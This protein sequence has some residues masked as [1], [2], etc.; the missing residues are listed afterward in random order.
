MNGDNE[1]LKIVNN[2][3]SSNSNIMWY[4]ES[5]APQ[6]RMWTDAQLIPY[7][8]PVLEDGQSYQVQIGYEL[9]NIVTYHKNVELTPDASWRVFSSPALLNVI[10]TGNYYVDLHDAM[11]R[12]IPFGLNKMSVQD[13]HIIFQDRFPA[14]FALPLYAD[15][16][17]YDGHTED[18][19]LR[20]DGSTPMIDGYVPTNDYDVVTKKYLLEKYGPAQ[21]LE[22][23][24]PDFIDKAT[25]W[26][27]DLKK[28][29]TSV[30][31]NEEFNFL[32]E[33]ETL[34]IQCSPIYNV[35]KGVIYLCINDY[36]VASIPLKEA[37]DGLY[38]GLLNVKVIDPYEKTLL[39][40]GHYQSLVI[41][42]AINVKDFL[43]YVGNVSS[44]MR[45]RLEWRYNAERKFTNE[46]IYGIA[47]VQRPFKIENLKISNVNEVVQ[48]YI[49][50]IPTLKEGTSF[51][52]SGDIQGIRKFKNP[53]LAKYDCSFH[54]EKLIN[55]DLTYTTNFPKYHFNLECKVPENF[56]CD[57]FHFMIR[58]F[59]ILREQQAVKAFWHK[60]YIDTVSVE[61]RVTSGE[62]LFPLNFGKEYD[63]EQSLVDNHELMLKNGIYQFPEGNYS[64]YNPELGLESE[65][66]KG[67]NYD[68]IPHETRWATFRYDLDYCSGL[69]IN[70]EDFECIYDKET[71][72]LNEVY[73]FVKTPT[74]GWLNANK[75]YN[76]ISTPK[77][78]DDAA[79]VIP[80][81]TYDK[82]YVTFGTEMIKGPFFVRIGFANNTKFKRIDCIAN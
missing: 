3:I 29:A 78:D 33:N 72:I 13:G 60:F 15:F 2:K 36:D 81:S 68:K 40:H 35:G 66:L 65:L 53:L 20:N 48:K 47:P 73:L 74:T 69:F 12:E 30:L 55:N 56:Y 44:Y 28:T 32:F 77:N 11:G 7:E 51:Y 19:Y 63:H 70:I 27:D 34:N 8:P 76:G 10:F 26:S 62:G 43:I 45:V 1:V 37:A 52:V 42:A 49:S 59:D 50:G 25:L 4:E 39:S 6:K 75:P 38:S 31:T 5:S 54:E 21:K 57:N 46:L 71:G 79:Y 64:L 24:K 80:N 58:A 61:D 14:G 22:P 17:T 23:R 18:V 82:R 67:P 16:Y 9:T 41:T